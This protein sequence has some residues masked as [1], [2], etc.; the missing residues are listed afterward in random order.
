MPA[1]T[2]Q[3][4]VKVITTAL[5]E[6]NASSLLLLLPQG[7]PRRFLVQLGNTTFELWIYSWTLTH[8]GGVARPKNEYRIQLTSVQPPLQVNPN[9]PTLLVGYEPNTQ[10][11][12]G[13]DLSK[14][15][16]FST[17]SPSIQIPITTLNDALQYGLSFVRK[18][19]DEIAIGIRPD[20]FLA[21]CL[22]A[23]ILHKEGADAQMVDLLTRVSSL[24]IISEA[25]V[26]QVPPERER[27]LREVSK[28][29]RDS[30]FRRKILHAYDHRCAVTRIQLRLIDAAHILPVGA[31]GSTDEITN[32]IC[33]SPTYH[34]AF[35]RAFIY[36]DESLQMQINPAKEQ[37]LIAHG[38]DGGLDYFKT[39]LGI[40][41][42]LPAD[43]SWWPHLAYIREANKVRGIH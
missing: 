38:L 15:Q 19:N 1:L 34:R 6:S 11:F 43:R 18:G 3:Q 17:R 12:A 5:D 23:A 16:L 25:E 22:H 33:L 2:P 4:T 10:C 24:E 36:L 42:H 35:D 37:E 21:Y 27:I 39:Y 30:S 26:G 9:G 41:I 7:N 14:H 8:G 32:G 29:S 28:L 20:Q 13:F 40:R 31:E